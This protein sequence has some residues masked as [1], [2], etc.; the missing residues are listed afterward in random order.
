MA[1]PSLAPARPAGSSGAAP[2]R[3]GGGYSLAPPGAGGGGD[4]GIGEGLFTLSSPILNGAF[5]LVS[6]RGCHTVKGD[7]THAFEV[8][9]LGT[10]T[11]T[12]TDIY[13]YIYIY[14]YI[15]FRYKTKEIKLNSEKENALVFSFV[16]KHFY[17]SE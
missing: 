11:I 1:P 4:E 15:R 9:R 14:I 12:S 7:A 16:S 13:I 5:S 10:S 6:K 8:Y 3:T 2:G 17:S